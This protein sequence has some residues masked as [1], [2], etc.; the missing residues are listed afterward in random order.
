M[1]QHL[2]AIDHRRRSLTIPRRL[3]PSVLAIRAG[4]PGA[5]DAVDELRAR[6]VIA[7]DSLDPL[8]ADLV[9]VM[10]NPSLVV[11]AEA[12]RVHAGVDVRARLS[13]FWRS[14]PR[15]VIGQTDDKRHFQLLQ[16]E[17]ML[18]PFHMAQAV[19]MVPR[20][21]PQFHGSFR[22]PASTLSVIETLAATNPTAAEG[23]L[24]A[25]GVARQWA[26]RLLAALLLRRSLW[27]VESVWLGGTTEREESRL[28]VL[29]GGFAGYWRLSTEPDDTVTVAPCSFDDL[30]VRIAALLPGHK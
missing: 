5:A 15:A 8:V 19:G 7:A 21:H 23:E 25:A 24:A 29:D 12:R 18:L 4:K 20:P 10:T 13:T 11:S 30:L 6:G 17:P 28:S 22:V 16:I 1:T 3:M 9:D 2:P 27:T 26:D 14:G